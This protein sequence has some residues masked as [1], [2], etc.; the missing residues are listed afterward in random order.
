MN[1]AGLLGV[2]FWF[3]ALWIPS[4]AAAGEERL[5]F[6]RN[7]TTGV[8]D[9]LP[10]CVTTGTEH[11]SLSHLCRT[12]GLAFRWDLF[13]ERMTI[14]QGDTAL[15]FTRDNTFF[16][17]GD[18]IFQL[19]YPPQRSGGNLYLS[20][21]DAAEVFSR[22]PGVVVAWSEQEKKLSIAARGNAPKPA[23][24]G[25]A[26]RESAAP[27]APDSAVLKTTGSG[28]TVSKSD[29]TQQTVKIKTIVIDPGHGG[30]DPGAI[31]PSGVKE[32]DVVLAIG[33]ALRDALEKA[34][35]VKVFMTRSSDKF[36]PL[37]KRTQI[38]NEKEADLFVSIHANSIG[39]NTKRKDT[40]K[41][42]KIFFLSQAK[43]EDDKLTAMIEN[44]VIELEDEGQ[45][46]N[47]LQKI[48]VQMAQ[49]EFLTE[50]QDMSILIAESFEKSLK[51]TTKLHTGVG[52]ANFYV[53]NGAFMPSVLVESS[54]ISNPVEEKLLADEGFQKKVALAICDAIV[55]FKKRYEESL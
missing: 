6:A 33:L 39:G 27:P 21:Q 51:K 4:A 17:Y 40:V 55:Q 35:L 2:L 44:S 26:A 43:D 7:S 36:I 52:Q 16:L 15:S 23:E 12:L 47:Y 32:K 30:R 19:R 20:L 45:K 34:N 37:C 22:F 46:G 10:S 48:L 1:K 24:K 13:A 38:A 49:C 11:V 14:V 42:Y 25:P 5:V 18:S 29:D 31:G 28:D 9:T 53:L 50:S 3:M 41:G 54:F 8:I